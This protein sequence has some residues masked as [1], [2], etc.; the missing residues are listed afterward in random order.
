MF[1]E[2]VTACI[3]KA[4]CLGHYELLSKPG[5]L[6]EFATQQIKTHTVPLTSTGKSLDMVSQRH[7]AQGNLPSQ[8]TFNPRLWEFLHRGGPRIWI[9]RRGSKEEKFVG[10]NM[11]R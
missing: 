6:H 2:R 9:L 5:L 10:R 11:K 4:A 3:L 8:V 7:Q 1:F